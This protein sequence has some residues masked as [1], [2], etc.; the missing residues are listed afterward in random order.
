LAT[1]RIHFLILR[2]EPER[3]TRHPLHRYSQLSCV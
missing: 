2:G 3:A 1:E